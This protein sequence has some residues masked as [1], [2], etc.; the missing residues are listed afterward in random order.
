MKPDPDSSATNS[1]LSARVNSD[2][3]ATPPC[4]SIRIGHISQRYVI[5]AQHLAML[6]IVQ[7][8]IH[9]SF[10]YSETCHFPKSAKWPKAMQEKYD[11]L[12]KNYTWNIVVI[13]D[14]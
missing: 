1:N 7:E 2:I 11:T 6:T 13:P 5:I 14:S 3:E 8:V 10:T 9:K 12:I 4:Q